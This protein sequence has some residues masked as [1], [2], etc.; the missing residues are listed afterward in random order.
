MIFP[1]TTT[2]D[3]LIADI[4]G[5]DL[6]YIK[7]G[8]SYNVYGF[9]D[10]GNLIVI[11]IEI[12]EPITMQNT[13]A[14]KQLQAVLTHITTS[15]EVAGPITITSAAGGVV[16]GVGGGVPGPVTASLTGAAPVAGVII[17]TPATPSTTKIL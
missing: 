16:V 8:V 5:F 10:E 3:P 4:L 6:T 13:T 2:F 7:P 12:S 15:A 1:L 17:S 9:D 14:Y 11:D